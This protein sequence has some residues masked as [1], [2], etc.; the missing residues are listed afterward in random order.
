MVC[1]C[2][3][4]C[5]CVCVSLVCVCQCVCVCVSV[6]T[7][8]CVHVCVQLCVSECV[9]VL[10]MFLMQVPLV[11]RSCLLSSL[12]DTVNTSYN[13]FAN[14]NLSVV[15]VARA[16]HLP[17]WLEKW[18]TEF[19]KHSRLCNNQDPPCGPASQKW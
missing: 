4:V 9:T 12:T 8:V 13:L 11:K 17:V 5:V 1:V 10:P 2:V 14:Q 15:S 7:C 6:C 18:S 3:S 16:G 19:P